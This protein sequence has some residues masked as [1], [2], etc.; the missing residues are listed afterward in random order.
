MHFTNI[1][2]EWK[3]TKTIEKIMVFGAFDG[4]VKGAETHSKA[5]GFFMLWRGTVCKLKDVKKH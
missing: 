1:A 2:I 5:N 4:E 3:E